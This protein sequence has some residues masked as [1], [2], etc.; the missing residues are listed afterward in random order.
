MRKSLILIS[1]VLAV[2]LICYNLLKDKIVR[3]PVYHIIAIECNKRDSLFNLVLLTANNRKQSISFKSQ[4]KQDYENLARVISYVEKCGIPKKHEL[5]EQ[6]FV[7]LWSIL[8]HIPEEDIRKKYFYVIERMKQDS[9]IHPELHALMK[10][11]IL[12]EE[13]KPQLFGTQN[14]NGKL[15]K[16]DNMDSVQSRRIKIGLKPL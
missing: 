6:Q 9:S 11:R 10:D 5:S 3:V 2:L 13:N 8:Q 7:A 14:Y 16:V 1:S 12:M 4:I 15:Y